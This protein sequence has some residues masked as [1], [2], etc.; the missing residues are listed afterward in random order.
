MQKVKDIIHE[1]IS[2]DGLDVGFIA[3]KMYM[4]HSTLYRKV[5]AVTGLS[6]AGLVRKLRAR[7]AGELL[8][9]GSHTVSEVAY[10]VGMSSLGN[11]RQ[12][13][14]EEFGISPS[15]YIKNAR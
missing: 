6:V 14:K 8:A 11:F 10:M 3:D 1:N 9:E 12:C 4:S 7:R 15:E 2:N 13:F 5:K